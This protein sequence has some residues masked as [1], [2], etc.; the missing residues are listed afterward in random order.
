MSNISIEAVDHVISEELLSLYTKERP[1]TIGK[2]SFRISNFNIE[3]DHACAQLEKLNE[4]APTW[5]GVLLE[6]DQ[7]KEQIKELRTEKFDAL[8]EL[9]AMIKKCAEANNV[10]IDQSVQLESLNNTTPHEQ[11][12]CDMLLRML[13]GEK[14]ERSS[15]SG[16][17][18]SASTGIHLDVKYRK[19]LNKLVVPWCDIQQHYKYA[20]INA[21]RKL[22]L[23]TKRPTNT[24]IMG[25]VWYSSEGSYGDV[26]DIK[27]DASGIDWRNSLT[28]RPE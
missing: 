14:V 20:T 4:Q 21:N 1:I 9:N 27:V 15:R 26:S 22:L 16:H 19:P 17:W 13:R 2:L 5:G 3:G 12:M 25:N 8:K 24:G 7:L 23:F 10:I 6:C 11:H 28:K 18:R